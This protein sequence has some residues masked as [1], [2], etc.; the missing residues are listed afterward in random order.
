MPPA[1]GQR[2][3]A[4]SRP[5]RF[6]RL[7]APYAVPVLH[8]TAAPAT[9]DNSSGTRTR[10]PARA[11]L[12]NSGAAAVRSD[13]VHGNAS[14]AELRPAD[15]QQ[16][17]EGP[18]W[19][20]VT[21]IDHP[22]ALYRRLALRNAGAA[23]RH[24]SAGLVPRDKGFLQISETQSGLGASPRRRPAVL[25]VRA[26]HARGLRSGSPLRPGRAWARESRGSRPCDC[27]GKPRWRTGASCQKK[28]RRAPA[29][30]PTNRG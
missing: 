27:R 4:W 22:L 7:S 12:R 15:A 20:V 10:A 29:F 3:R 21:R 2:P 19:G 25:E 8:D 28:G 24:H 5:R 1:P 17:S 18:K 26:A 13:A 30:F 6:M 14:L 23:R 9:K 16:C 11:P